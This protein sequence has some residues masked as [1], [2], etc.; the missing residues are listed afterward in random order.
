MAKDTPMKEAQKAKSTKKGT[1]KKKT[2]KREDS[3]KK[4]SPTKQRL[5]RGLIQSFEVCGER[6]KEL[7]ITYELSLSGFGLI[8]A[9]PDDL[10]K[11]KEQ[12]DQDLSDSWVDDWSAID[13]ASLESQLDKLA[14]AVEVG[15]NLTEAEQEAIKAQE[16]LSRGLPMV[17]SQ[18]LISL[19]ATLESFIHMLVA[20]VLSNDTNIRQNAN[21]RKIKIP[22]VDFETLDSQERSYFVIRELEHK[23]AA[24]HRKGI[25]CFESLLD[26]F[27]LGGGLQET[28]RRDLLELQQIRHVLVHRRG[29]VDRQLTDACP[30]LKLEI[31]CKIDIT[32]E[33]IRKYFKAVNE[34]LSEISRRIVKKYGTRR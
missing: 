3:L 26:V 34:Y 19:W 30:W 4:S 20:S 28:Y 32:R 24:S 29:L 18:T 23:L 12:V 7:A 9:R 27:E 6:L 33:D 14:K 16:M 13:R 8:K 2:R 17:H 15:L 31:N 1:S 11:L 25:G 5:K 22:L 10:Q 21:I